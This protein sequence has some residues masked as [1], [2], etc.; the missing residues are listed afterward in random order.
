MPLTHCDCDLSEGS[1]CNEPICLS[2]LQKRVCEIP[3]NSLLL[4]Q[5][6]SEPRDEESRSCRSCQPVSTGNESAKNCQSLR[7]VS[8]GCSQNTQERG[9]SVSEGRSTNRE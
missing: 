5:C 2:I 1:S 4:Q 7:G 3:Q 9:C 8:E 6:L